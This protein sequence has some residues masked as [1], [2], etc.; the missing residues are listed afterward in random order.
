MLNRYW[1]KWTLNCAFGE[2][3]GLGAAGGIAYLVNAYFGEPTEWLPKLLVLLCMM[4]AGFIEGSLLGFFQWR[5]LKEKFTRLPRRSWMGY[6]IAI[7]VIGWFLGMLPS[8]FFIPQAPSPA[9]S[10][11]VDLD[12][13]LLFAL[14][15]IGSGLLLGALFGLFQ[16]FPL[17][18]H[19][20]K[21]SRWILANALGWGL[22]L[23]WIYLFASLPNEE[24]PMYVL[25]V[26][27]VI[28]GILTGL[29]VGAVTGLFLVKMKKI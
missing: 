19:A 13:P 17:K 11:G 3:A 7:A 5:V 24:S 4:M 28:G 9:Q 1:L 16:Y 21:A 26:A 22:G 14:L 6:T 8:L 29:S 2:L 10:A 27:G 12:Q 25:I 18:K 23:G 15:A 20:Q